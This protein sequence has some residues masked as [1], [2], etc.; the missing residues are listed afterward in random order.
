[1][2]RF[3]QYVGDR[4]W[5]VSVAVIAAAMLYVI[6]RIIPG[7]TEEDNVLLGMVTMVIAGAVIRARVWSNQTIGEL[8]G[9]DD[10]DEP[11]TPVEGD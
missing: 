3:M 10:D 11:V 2:G 5:S 8:F 9:I 6:N 4:E 1:M 7:L